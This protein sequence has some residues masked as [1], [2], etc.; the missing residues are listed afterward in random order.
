MCSVAVGGS[1]AKPMT[2]EATQLVPAHALFVAATC[3]AAYS[4]L[5]TYALAACFLLQRSTIQ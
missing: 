5:Q 4:E 1:T 3:A 2:L